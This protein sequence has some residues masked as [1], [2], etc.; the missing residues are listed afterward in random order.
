[1]SRP[2]PLI[3]A[4]ALPVALVAQTVVL[5]E[6]SL[7]DR[8]GER[9]HTL[10]MDAWGEQSANTVYNELLLA[11]LR[12]GYLERDL[13]GRSRDAT[14]ER[15]SLGYDVGLRIQWTGTEG[16]GPKGLRP[17]V[18]AGYREVLGT[19]FSKDLFVMAFFGNAGYEDR[20]AVLGGSAH[21]SMRY[22]TVG[23]G[24]ASRDRRS[25]VR[26]D[27]V[28]GR[29]MN[30]SDLR[31]ADVYTGVDGRTI[32]ADVLGHYWS[33]D[34][35]DQRTWKGSGLALSG[36]WSMRTI[37]EERPVEIAFGVQD[38]GFIV[39]ND[40]SLRL[41]R[42]TLITYEGLVVDDVFDLA[43]VL[44][45][46]EQLLDTFGLRYEKGAYRSLLPFRAE[47]EMN[48]TLPN[49]WYTGFLLQQVNLPGFVPQFSAFGAK[50]LGGRTLVGAELTA[51]GFGG[52]R[53]GGRVRHRFG[54]RL[55]GTLG[56]SHFPGLATGRTRGFGL[57]MTV[58]AGF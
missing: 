21:M 26:L 1:M 55:W 39:W 48:I 4:L 33:S 12:G 58:A 46:G 56:C 29:S 19:R 11:L 27:L 6:D 8:P 44:S 30:A 45:D 2:F 7:V 37:S 31:V 50:R 53:V 14:M 3:L 13:R 36:R 43:G 40:R 17:V 24:V 57:R 52:I 5:P 49:G 32:E 23:A 22:R 9:S 18:S 54:G 35:A 28:D 51:G 34:T 41:S 10:S 47:M 42:D 15:N 16:K 25:H 20:R 38:L